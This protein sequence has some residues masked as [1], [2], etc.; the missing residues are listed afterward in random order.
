MFS[1]DD[2]L[3]K[4]CLKGDSSAFGFL[5]DKYKGAVHAL[6][7]RKVRNFEDAEDIAQEAFLK[8]YQNLESLKQPHCFASWLYAIT[9]NCA[10]MW[11]RK[12]QK[13][14]QT[15]VALEEVSQAD[16]A[17]FSIQA[18]SAKG[19]QE[20]VHDAINALPESYRLPISLHYLGG[21]SCHEIASFLGTSTNAILVKLHR[22]RQKLRKEML[23]MIEAEFA[24]QQLKPGFT[25]H[26]MERLRPHPISTSPSPLRRIGD[27]VT[28]STIAALT[29]FLGIGLWFVR[30]QTE[31]GQ[32]FRTPDFVSVLFL[33]GESASGEADRTILPTSG[34]EKKS[35]V[36]ESDLPMALARRR[37]NDKPL[38]SDS[39]GTMTVEYFDLGE[40]KWQPGMLGNAKP[41]TKLWQQQ[42]TKGKKMELSGIVVKN[43]GTPIADAQVLAYPTFIQTMLRTATVRLLTTTNKDGTFTFGKLPMIGKELL[44]YAFVVLAPGHG[45]GWKFLFPKMDKPEEVYMLEWLKGGKTS[46][47]NY[48]PKAITIMLSDAASITGRVTD[49]NGNPLKGATAEVYGIEIA[50]DVPPSLGTNAGFAVATTDAEGMFEL[51]GLPE[52]TKISLILS[53]P[54]YASQIHHGIM[55]DAEEVNFQLERGGNIE[56]RVT[57]SDGKPAQ[58]VRMVCEE[59]ATW[60]DEHGEY[61]FTDV[62]P[63]DANIAVAYI[64]Y[65][66]EFGEYIPKEKK[67][68]VMVMAERI[69]KDVNLQL[70]KAGYITGKIIDKDT[71][72]PI[73]NAIVQVAE[74]IEVTDEKGIY[75][76]RVRPGQV[77]IT[78]SLPWSYGKYS[79]NVSH[80]TSGGQHWVKVSPGKTVKKINFQFSKTT[81]LTGTVVGPEGK[82]VAGVTI[83]SWS[84]PPAETKSN[85][86][87][88]FTLKGLKPGQKLKTLSANHPKLLLRGTYGEVIVGIDDDITI[89][90]EKY[91][92]GKV[93]R[94]VLDAEDKPIPSAEIHLHFVATKSYKSGISQTDAQGHFDINTVVVGDEYFIGITAKGYKSF[95]SENFIAKQNPIQMED[96][97]LEKSGDGFIAGRIT[98]ENGKPL[99]AGLWIIDPLLRISVRV[100]IDSQGYYRIEY[101]STPT[102]E[103]DIHAIDKRVGLSIMDIPTNRTDIN[104]AL[105][106]SENGKHDDVSWN[107]LQIIGK[108][109]PELDVAAWFNSEPITLKQLKGKVVV[110]NFR[111]IWNGNRDVPLLNQLHQEYSDKGLVIIVIFDVNR[112]TEKISE[113][114]SRHQIRY[115]VAQDQLPSDGKGN[116]KTFSKYG[117]I[118]K[119]DLVLINQNGIFEGRVEASILKEKIEAL[120][121]K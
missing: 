50:S 32:K 95:R 2:N 76:I 81:S 68:T 41:Q 94:R 29:I 51:Q 93:T 90:L 45:F 40:G 22:A 16:L 44:G 85:R 118:R 87:G 88:K 107:F 104:I 31:S 17:V 117:I 20:L 48:D 4:A 64:N 55:V 106:T 83:E 38:A 113:F 97:I 98:D 11:L 89:Q 5:V 19:E 35:P 3:V 27:L 108:A 62:P 119:P 103:I 121:N 57:Y 46:P 109:A 99:E 61:R 21:L 80:T 59:K 78:A 116:G 112:D 66:D 114:I 102:V 91:A 9:A 75:R 105:D 58:F 33:A 115:K 28:V 42:L 110:L 100:P 43:D 65:L 60:T 56:G 13:R 77:R 8:A 84:Y 52:D 120:L 37:E 69:V 18:H 101:L 72:E 82:P 6:A 15:A 96:I 10:R 67:R 63:G 24:Q 86:N 47:L 12:N 36:S 70:V 25:I 92:F 30:P 71:G 39:Q 34:G 53:H 79:K 26:L 49:A 7:Y 1:S 111:S 54:G 14:R 73:A 74:Q 23:K